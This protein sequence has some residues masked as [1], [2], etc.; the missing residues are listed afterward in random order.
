MFDYKTGYFFGFAAKIWW[1][2]SAAGLFAISSPL[3]IDLQ[4]PLSR[5]IIVG[6]VAL[7]I[8]ITL[9]LNYYG[10]Q[11]DRDKIRDYMAIYGIKIGRW[12]SIPQFQKVTFTSRNVSSW[13]TSNGISPTFKTNTTIYTI[14]LFSKKENPDFFIQTEDYKIANEK[15]EELS[16]LLGIGLERI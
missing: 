2:F 10:L 6:V 12:Q 13:N 4:V 16:E 5:V 1:Q 8:G 14:A 3:I 15:A 9:K 11:I 7:L